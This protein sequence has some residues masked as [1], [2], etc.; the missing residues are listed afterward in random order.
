MFLQ[1]FHC[2][3]MQLAKTLPKKA[4]RAHKQYNVFKELQTPV[5]EEESDHLDK[6]LWASH[7]SD[8]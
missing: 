5:N 6:K 1:L 7:K 4:G 8:L 2:F 3:S